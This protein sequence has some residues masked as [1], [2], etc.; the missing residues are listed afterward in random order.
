MRYIT[1]S[2]MFRL[3][4][5][6]SILARSTREPSGNSPACHALEQVEVLLHRAIAV[7]AVLAGLG[8]RAAVLADLVG[9]QVVDVGLAVLDQLD[10]PLVELLEIVGGVVEAVPLEAQPAHVLLDGIDVLRLFLRRVGVVE[11]QV[12]R[13]AE[14]V[15][16]AEIEAD[17]LGVA[18]VQ[19]AVGLGRKARLDAAPPYLLVFRSSMN[20][21]ADEVG[22]RGS[23]ARV[24]AHFRLGI[25]RCHRLILSQGNAPPLL[26]PEKARPMVARVRLPGAAPSIRHKGYG[27]DY[28][29]GELVHS[30]AYVPQTCAS[31]APLHCRS[32]RPRSIL[33]H[34][35]FLCA[36]RF[37]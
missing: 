25:R 13:A 8:Q 2:R 11:A 18:D 6:M 35:E 37:S 10:R 23:G 30:P 17:R 14:L 34:L 26:R 19:V 22:G 1:G 20:D 29:H 5:A 36:G 12:G 32:R 16:Q 9:G 3:G 27:R 4:D 21:V 28:V 7:R 24:A 15:G 33:C 31:L